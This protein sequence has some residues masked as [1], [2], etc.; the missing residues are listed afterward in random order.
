MAKFIID[1][2]ASEKSNLHQSRPAHTWAWKTSYVIGLVM[3][4]RLQGGLGISSPL[5]PEVVEAM[6]DGARVDADAKSVTSQW[7]AAGF[8]A[9]VADLLKVD[10]KVDAIRA[11]MNSDRLQISPEELE[12]IYLEIGGE[13]T[14]VPWPAYAPPEQK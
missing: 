4:D 7:D 5:T 3:A 10:R 6:A 2:T 11:F 1:W 9:G 14:T 12:L 8:R 13:E